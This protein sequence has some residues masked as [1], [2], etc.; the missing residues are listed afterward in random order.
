LQFIHFE[1]ARSDKGLDGQGFRTLDMP[2]AGIFPL[3]AAVTLLL[4]EVIAALSATV[5]GQH[6]AVPGQVC[7]E[8]DS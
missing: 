2:S 6:S 7:A 8:S 1:K 4:S 3:S 5:D